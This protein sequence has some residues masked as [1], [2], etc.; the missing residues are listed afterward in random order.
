MK[1]D[2]IDITDPEDV[3]ASR[4]WAARRAAAALALRQAQARRAVLAQTLSQNPAAAALAAVTADEAT[5]ARS[6]DAVKTAQDARTEADRI[7]RLY[8]AN[9]VATAQQELDDAT[10]A[11]SAA[12]AQLLSE[13]STSTA[14]TAT[15]DG[16]ALRTRY[17]SATA[18]EPPLWD[19]ATIPFKARAGDIPLDP[20]LEFPATDEPDYPL[21][22]DVLRRLGD[23]VDAVADLVT[24]EGVHQLVNGNPTRSGAAL[25]I[26][27]TGSVPDDLEV[28]TT[29][30]PAVD[31]TQRLLLLAQPEQ[32]PAWTATSPG[33]A[34]VADPD[35]SAWAST[36]LPDPAQ[37]RLVAQRTDPATGQ[38]GPPLPLTADLL[39]LDPLSWL[40]VAAD[41]GELS[42]RIARLAR[43]RWSAALGEAAAFGGVL[44]HDPD[45][46]D[47]TT[48]A[49]S[50][51]LAA[52]DAA[53]AVLATSRAL[54]PSDLASPAGAGPV[55][56]DESAGQALD[57]V[58]A[59]ERHVDDMLADLRA[60][61]AAGATVDTV[62]DALFAAAGVGIAEATPTLDVE[63][64]SLQTLQTQAA[65]A[66]TRLQARTAGGPFTPTAGD[67]QSTLDGARARLSQLAGSRQPLLTSVATPA[68]PLLRTDLGVGPVRISKA[69][70]ATLRTWLHQHARVRPAA[71]ALMSAYDLAEALGCPGH[72]DLRAT[73]M[74][75][76][77]PDRWAQADPAPRPGVLAVVAACTYPRN[78]P[79]RVTGLAVDAW[80]HNL[81]AATHATGVA[82]SYDKPNAT[83]P[84]VILI[85]VAPDVRPGRQPRSWDLDTLLDIV[86]ATV[87]L[88]TAR[89][90]PTDE[91]PA[92]TELTILDTP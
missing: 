86:T 2:T 50:D 5:V 47:P 79:A 26:A 70:P 85:A 45:P 55:S 81:P 10:R 52:A 82:F 48:L 35:L 8:E 92:G 75:T 22:L 40:R 27:A 41:R 88:A 11:V 60:A 67:P 51:L 12:L 87:T 59:A 56:D 23:R 44:A 34:G 15:V 33:L 4:E 1:T 66:V 84:Q 6:S 37:V 36:V 21:L 39:G 20:Q 46:R 78:V 64:P 54:A 63:T 62:L 42:A 68:N 91:A 16:L 7:A 65:I 80:V 43:S 30:T 13:A 57:Q 76:V 72:L 14:L 90:V 38:P 69:E 77:E 31:L 28:I 32:P 58:R 83:A 61:A 25:D 74:P 73:Q 53:R 89:A 29:P 24:A 17:Q 71:G 19:V 18:M 9:E 3:A 49:L